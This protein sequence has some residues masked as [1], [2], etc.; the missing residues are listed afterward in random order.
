VT[1]HQRV[2]TVNKAP[3]SITPKPDQSPHAANPLLR[4]LT[5][6][7]FWAQTS[8]HHL[9]DSDLHNYPTPSRRWVIPITCSGQT[10]RITRSH[11]YGTLTWLYASVIMQ[12][13]GW[14]R[15]SRSILANG[16]S[17]SCQEHS[18][19][20]GSGFAMP[21]AFLRNGRS[22]LQLL[23]GEDHPGTT[24]TTVH[25]GTAW[26]SRFCFNTSPAQRR[27]DST[28]SPPRPA[29]RLTYGYQIGLNDGTS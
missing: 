11:S 22:R 2:L 17:S 13:S 24:T 18:F 21:P 12:R 16:T 9:P 20:P 5:A 4:R 14:S 10:S 1:K 8:R 25:Q 27:W 6:A 29:E 26:R 15:D 19:P 3:L 28:A 23:P 7:L